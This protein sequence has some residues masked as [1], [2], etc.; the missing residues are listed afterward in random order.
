MSAP[1]SAF[2]QPVD[3]AGDRPTYTVVKDNIA[4]AANATDIFVLTASSGRIVRLARVRVSGTASG[5]QVPEIQLWKRTTANSGGSTQPVTPVPHDTQDPSST[6]TCVYYTAN[7][8]GLGTGQ[9]LRAEHLSAPGTTG[10]AITPTTLIW[11]FSNLGIKPLVLR[12]GESIAV[13]FAG[14]AVPTGLALDVT[15]E[16]SEDT[17]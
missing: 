4:P 6:C 15:I 8:S 9:L 11:D 13:N 5:N 14:N 1:R 10:P 12:A 7:P 17:V 16:Y 2:T 3:V